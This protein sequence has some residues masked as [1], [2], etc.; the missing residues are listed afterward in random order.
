MPTSIVK[1][2]RNIETDAARDIKGTVSV[3]NKAP[4]KTLL[5]LTKNNLKKVQWES[6]LNTISFTLTDDQTC[7][8][9]TRVLTKSH[10]FDQKKKIT[11]IE[12]IINTNEHFICQI[13]FYSEK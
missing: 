6:N 5:N 4:E 13:N 10:K 2:K 7:K 11:K 1:S 8:A 3:P 12:V 9:G